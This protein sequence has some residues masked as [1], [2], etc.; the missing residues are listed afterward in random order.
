MSVLLSVV[1]TGTL[2]SAGVYL[3]AVLDRL[4]GARVAG[5]RASVATALIA[6]A[7]GAAALL[8]QRRTTTERPDD[9]AWAVAPA[10][11]VA[12]AAVAVAAVP[13]GPDLAV[14]PVA[15]GLALYGAAI[16]M[17]LVAVFLHG[18]SPNSPF[19]LLG[20]YRFAAQGLSFPIPFIL[21]LISAGLAAE[22]LAVADIVRS[23]DGLWNLV[24]QPLGLP[25]F[26]VTGWGLAFWG[27]L[28]LP[29]ASD[30]AGGTTTEAS[31]GA[32]LAW[33]IGQHATLVAVAAMGAAAF[34]GGWHG[35][36]LPGPV[37]TVL[38]TVALL[39]VLVM[40]GHQVARVRIERFVLL[41]WVVLIPLA[42]V[43]VFASGA[44]AL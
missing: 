31:G 17:V 14:A 42:L 35:P 12:A 41:A 3:T 24:R 4:A 32:V 19:P 13:L 9:A 6:P 43:D 36:L 2:L 25:V 39:T 37:W 30:L 1:V 23:Q 18:W 27:P 22:S 21:T 28:A 34:L 38:K 44:L 11:L 33:R 8:V 26:L 16:S 29:D 15:D 10:L 20:A 7:A 5:R 40:G